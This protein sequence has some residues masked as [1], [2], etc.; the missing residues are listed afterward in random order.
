MQRFTPSCTALILTLACVSGLSIADAA[1]AGSADGTV[2]LGKVSHTLWQDLRPLVPFANEPFEVRFQSAAGDLTSARVIFLSDDFQVIASHPASI[3]RT[4]GPYDFWSAS[5]PATAD[6]IR[7]YAIEARDGG[8]IDYLGRLGTVD[9]FI[10]LT[11]FT[12]N[13]TTL[14]HAPIGATPR[15]NGG[16]V[17]RVWSPNSNT[18]HVRGDFNAWG[19]QNPMTKVGEHFIAY[20]PTAEVGLNYKYFFNNSVWNT[21]P[22]A[23]QI[24]EGPQLNAKIIDPLAYQWQSDSFTPDPIDQLVIYQLHV[25]TFSGRN[26]PVGTA[27]TPSRYRDVAN[28]VGHLVDMGVN[29][30]MLN[31]IHEFPGTQSGGYNGVSAWAIERSLGNPDDLK[32]MIDV[33]H[34]NGIAVILDI[35]WNHF[36]NTNN[37]LWNFNGT[38]LYYDNPAVNTPWGPQA[39]F[40][41]V[42]V[43][44]YF[45]DSVELLLGEYRF[46]GFRHDA[47][48]EMVSAAQPSSGQNIIRRMSDLITRR[49]EDSYTIAEIY[50]NDPWVVRDT[51]AGLGFNAQYHERF[52]NAL[53]D[54]LGAA[55]SGN[56]DIARLADATD[57]TAALVEGEHVMNYWELHDDAWPLNSGQ[58]RAAR[59]IDTTLPHDDQFA[60]GRT[61]LASGLTM[62]AK[63]IPA[64]LMGTEW[65]EDDGFEAT[66]IDW[67]HKNTYDPIVRYY[68][69]IIK[70]R[71]GTP[72]LFANAPTTITH[73]NDAQNIF[74]FVRSSPQDGRSYLAVANFSNSDFTGY[75]LGLPRPGRWGVVIN[76]ESAYYSGNG[77]G[78][79]G[80]FTAEAI[81]YD[82][83]AQS[84]AINIPARAFMLLQHDPEWIRQPED[85]NGNANTD[86]AVSFD[87]I[88]TVLANLGATYTPG[89]PNAPGDTDN[90][91]SVSFSDI[92]FVLASLGATCN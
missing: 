83:Q 30:V 19:L 22:R 37:F 11:P 44:D 26:D 39:N 28:R 12:L 80:E 5:V 33:L 52:K 59:E 8:D 72:S 87:D 51:P 54:A 46:D 48:Y 21:D 29:A 78:T 23:R 64:I 89:T 70:L 9:E 92:T 73:V 61:K 20:V 41:L 56:P 14:E 35:V 38:Q 43:R 10:D 40:D 90:N 66:K 47:L 62:F 71:T 17:F 63:G 53:Q 4:A 74:A 67:S 91:W 85:C 68:R 3:I 15:P 84:F 57:G 60:K 32:Y 1:R 79:E 88:T 55:A 36:G 86:F 49:F 65:L 7:H 69:D 76:S 25:G 50:N 18:V 42:G 24:S 16:T 2:N 75:R 77:G 81:S 27:P 82:G 58:Q 6:N 45:V 13:F 34:Q 31:P